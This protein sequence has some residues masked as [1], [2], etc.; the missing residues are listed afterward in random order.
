MD[1]NR[2]ENFINFPSIFLQIYLHNQWEIS[3][4]KVLTKDLGL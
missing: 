3:N 4:F 2:G 1:W